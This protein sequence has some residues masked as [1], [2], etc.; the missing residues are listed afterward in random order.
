MHERMYERT[1]SM[2]W[3]GKNEGESIFRHTQLIMRNVFAT[4]K[5]RR[6]TEDAAVEAGLF[7]RSICMLDRKDLSRSAV[8]KVKAMDSFT[9]MQQWHWNV[10]AETNVS[11][12]HEWHSCPKN[13]YRVSGL[14]RVNAY[15][16]II[17]HVKPEPHL[18]FL[19][20][21]LWAII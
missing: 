9:W 19:I 4:M 17:I 6:R 2:T 13:P 20:R 15:M 10:A 5:R 16:Y 14:E 11:E 12:W 1:D 8:V 18:F 21:N 3:S 7:A